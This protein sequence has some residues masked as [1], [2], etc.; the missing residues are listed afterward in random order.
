MMTLARKAAALT[1][2]LISVTA[3]NSPQRDKVDSAAGA[4]EE[5]VRTTLSVVDIDMGRHAGPD[6]KITDK[7]DE[8][9]PSDTIFAS[10]H[11]SGTAKGEAI[12]GTWTFPDASVVDQKA[13]AITQ[14][15]AYLAFFVAKP[16]GLAPGKYTFRLMVD[17]KE[18]RSKDVTVK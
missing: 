14:N 13:E 18:V 6:K 1:V 15:D 2:V 3:C 16:K 5:A 11:M 12:T 8:F 17:G 10:V 9:A 4:A 7:T